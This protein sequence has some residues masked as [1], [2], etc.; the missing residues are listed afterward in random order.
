MVSNL[1]SAALQNMLRVQAFGSDMTREQT[2][3]LYRLADH[4]N[5]NS[6]N[7]E[8]LANC[9]A[10]RQFPGEGVSIPMLISFAS[11]NQRLDGQGG[12]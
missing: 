4:D 10:A 6:V 5:S 3:E 12:S 11:L 7:E 8:E 2:D 1:V 9:L